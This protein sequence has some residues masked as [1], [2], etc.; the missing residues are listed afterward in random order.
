MLIRA[1]SQKSVVV[2]DFQLFP[3]SGFVDIRKMFPGTCQNLNL[4][5]LKSQHVCK[6]LKRAAKHCIL[7][8]KLRSPS[9]VRLVV[10]ACSRSVQKKQTPG[11]LEHVSCGFCRCLSI[12]GFPKWCRHRMTPTASQQG[13]CPTATGKQTRT[14][15]KYPVQGKH[16]SL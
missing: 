5:M 8:P 10:I 2:S 7:L 15:I 1:R 12:L 3:I 16:P 9:T 11:I 6:M 13:P 4:E 14:G